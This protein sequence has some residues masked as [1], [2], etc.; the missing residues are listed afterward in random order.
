MRSYVVQIGAKTQNDARVALSGAFMLTCNN[1][2]YKIDLRKL[3]LF[4]EVYRGDRSTSGMLALVTYL[5]GC[6][7][8]TLESR[9]GQVKSHQV[10]VKIKSSQ[11]RG[12]VKKNNG[13]LLFLDPKNIVLD[14]KII[15]LCALVQKL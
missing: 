5:S 10:K 1:G 6:F 2:R 13:A 7:M 8:G 12:Q 3:P 15:I 4:N 11:G 9:S 14:T